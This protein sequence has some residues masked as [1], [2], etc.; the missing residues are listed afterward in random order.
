MCTRSMVLSLCMSKIQSF[1]ILRRIQGA[2]HDRL[3]RQVDFSGA[4]ANVILA[5]A[6][7]A[8]SVSVKNRGSLQVPLVPTFLT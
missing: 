3:L 8:C 7:N 6:A 4:F 2:W 5:N 1:Y